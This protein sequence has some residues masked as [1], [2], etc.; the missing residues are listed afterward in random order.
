MVEWLITGCEVFG[1]DTLVT[2]QN[3]VGC[4]TK[5]KRK[6]YEWMLRLCQ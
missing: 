6:A 1:N 2:L 3:P 4:T 5:V